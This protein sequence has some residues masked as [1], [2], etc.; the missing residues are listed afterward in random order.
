MIDPTDVF[1]EKAEE[2]LEAAASELANGALRK[3]QDLVGAVIRGRTS[4]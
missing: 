2:N 3:A 1:L 4:R